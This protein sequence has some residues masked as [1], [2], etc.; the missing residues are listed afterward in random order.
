MTIFEFLKENYPDYI[1]GD[2]DCFI[3]YEC[4]SKFGFKDPPKDICGSISCE[5][6]WNREIESD[7]IESGVDES[8]VDESEG[9]SEGENV[10]KESALYDEFCDRIS[11]GNFELGPMLLAISSCGN[12]AML[13]AEEAYELREL[14]KK[15]SSVYD[16]LKQVILEEQNKAAFCDDAKL[17]TDIFESY[18]SGKISKEQRDELIRMVLPSK[19]IA[20]L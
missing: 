1:W 14:A 13:T 20:L 6:C 10:K 11:K 7:V 5:E 9:E 4:P 15:N 2:F 16:L 19:K 17:I 18:E 3:A 8:R 12:A